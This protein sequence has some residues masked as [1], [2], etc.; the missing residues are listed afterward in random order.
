MYRELEGSLGINKYYYDD[1]ADVSP[2][3]SS[4]RLYGLD[5]NMEYSRR[6]GQSKPSKR[7][8]WY[9]HTRTGTLTRSSMT[10]TLNS[11]LPSRRPR[12]RRGS[13]TW[14]RCWR[15]F[16]CW[17]RTRWG[18][19]LCTCSTYMRHLNLHQPQGEDTALGAVSNL[20]SWWWRELTWGKCWT[21][22]S[23]RLFTLS[24]TSPITLK[25]ARALELIPRSARESW[26]TNCSCRRKCTMRN[27]IWSKLSR[28][29]WERP[30]KMPRV[31]SRSTSSKIA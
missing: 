3:N 22:Y 20:I 29:C 7:L 31:L 19:R 24:L 27:R 23:L 6:R 15:A 17:L 10:Y 21:T 26:S 4:F 5:L 1:I 28:Q 11:W 25:P 14:A 30:Q 18:T 16:C 12:A 9:L 13:S 8:G 2:M